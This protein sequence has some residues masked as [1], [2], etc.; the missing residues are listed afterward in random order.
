MAKTICTRCKG[1]GRTWSP[2][3]LNCG[4]KR[5]CVV[6]SGMGKVLVTCPWCK[7]AGEV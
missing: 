4:G 3:Q 5:N 6:C 2:C 1:Q 7:G